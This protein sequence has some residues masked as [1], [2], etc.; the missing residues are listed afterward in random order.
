MSDERI[1]L[2]S[3]TATFILVYAQMILGRV[4]S[5]RGFV[6]FPFHLALAGAILTVLAAISLDILNRKKGHLIWRLLPL[7]SSVLVAIQ[8]PVGMILL[9]GSGGPLLMVHIGLGGLAFLAC[10]VFFA[11]SALDSFRNG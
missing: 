2:K 3:G 9:G 11:V 1:F 7:T 8:G 4:I 6:Y 10:L 5:N